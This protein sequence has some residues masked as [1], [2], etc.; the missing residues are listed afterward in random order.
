[1]GSGGRARSVAVM[2]AVVPGRARAAEIL[3]DVSRACA[4]GLRTNARWASPASL[5]SSTYRPFPVRSL[6]SSTRFI[7]RPMY[8][9][10]SVIAP[11][12]QSG[13]P[14]SHEGLCHHSLAHLYHTVAPPSQAAEPAAVSRAEE[15]SAPHSP[16]PRHH[17]LTEPLELLG[18]FLKAVHGEV[19]DDVSS[20]S[21]D[22]AEVFDTADPLDAVLDTPGSGAQD[23][24]RVWPSGRAIFGRQ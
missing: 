6:V 10:E 7:G 12:G 11:S 13:R 1:R 5:T 18:Q 4:C 24:G 21:P 16:R 23:Q 8:G 14:F 3:R 20:P 9:A 15:W 19:Q 22:E 17:R 2:T